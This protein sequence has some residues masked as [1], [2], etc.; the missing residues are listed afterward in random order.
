MSGGEIESTSGRSGTHGARQPRSQGFSQK[1][2]ALGTRLG[3][4]G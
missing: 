2:K 4:R 3:A 1:G